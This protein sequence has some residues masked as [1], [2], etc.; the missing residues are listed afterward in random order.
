MTAETTLPETTRRETG[1]CCWCRPERYSG[2]Q[3]AWLHCLASFPGDALPGHGVHQIGRRTERTPV[4]YGIHKSRLTTVHMTIA[5]IRAL[6]LHSTHILHYRGHNWSPSGRSR[7]YHCP[8]GVCVCVCAMT[9]ATKEPLGRRTVGSAQQYGQPAI[10]LVRHRSLVPNDADCPHTTYQRPSISVVQRRV[11][12]LCACG[13]SSARYPPL[14]VQG[15]HGAVFAL[16]HGRPWPDPKCT[17]R[18]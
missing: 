6:K 4:C 11:S 8:V 16:C 2:V 1:R 9:G 10:W 7:A 12:K 3:T 5:Q 14:A 17:K 15:Q 18:T 13:R